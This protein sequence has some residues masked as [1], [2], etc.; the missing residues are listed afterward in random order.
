MIRLLAIVVLLT[1]VAAA[2]EHRTEPRSKPR[3]EARAQRSRTAPAPRSAANRREFQRLHPCPSTGQPTGSC[4]G[5]VVDHIIPLKRG[6]LDAPSNMQWQTIA[7]AKAKD[8]V[9]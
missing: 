7:E 1:S 5:Y 9:E 3:D 4:T 6:G 8:R 2:A